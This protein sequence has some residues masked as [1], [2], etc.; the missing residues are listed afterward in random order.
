MLHQKS[1]SYNC[2]SLYSCNLHLSR[3]PKKKEHTP[4]D[5]KRQ[6]GKAVA[7]LLEEVKEREDQHHQ[8]EDEVLMKE[9]E[10]EKFEEE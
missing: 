10:K 5:H 4:Q 2:K 7:K 1:A 6:H 8:D 9:E 3:M